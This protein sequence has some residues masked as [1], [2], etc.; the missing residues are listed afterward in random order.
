MRARFV[1]SGPARQ[2]HAPVLDTLHPAGARTVV[3]PQG[4]DTDTFVAGRRGQELVDSPHVRTTAQAS[5]RHRLPRAREVLYPEPQDC[6]DDSVAG[7]YA[8]LLHH[9]LPSRFRRLSVERSACAPGLLGNFDVSQPDTVNR[10][11]LPSHT[12]PAARLRAAHPQVPYAPRTV[13][14]TAFRSGS[15]RSC[16]DVDLQAR[17]AFVGPLSASPQ[18][19][20]TITYQ[21]ARTVPLALVSQESEP[22][23]LEQPTIVFGFLERCTYDQRQ[24]TQSLGRV[25]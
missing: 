20:A 18:A 5:C 24:S 22:I 15:L 10:P 11:G 3:T 16:R 17:V 21:R 2:V 12:Q 13:S 23:L 25:P 6:S 4:S 19:P 1:P 9:P 7:Q 14:S 8:R